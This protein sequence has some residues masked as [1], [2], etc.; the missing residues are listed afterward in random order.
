VSALF[1]FSCSALNSTKPV[2]TIED[3]KGMKIAVRR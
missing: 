3:L 1:N 2:K